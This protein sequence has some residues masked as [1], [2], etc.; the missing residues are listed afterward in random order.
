MSNPRHVSLD[1]AVSLVY[2]ALMKQLADEVPFKAAFANPVDDSSVLKLPHWLYL[3]STPTERGGNSSQL[4]EMQANFDEQ[5]EVA[6][7]EM[8]ED[9]QRQIATLQATLLEEF[10]RSRV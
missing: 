9:M 7:A 2:E 10:R 8:K 1:Q 4:A 6:K 5:L 3:V